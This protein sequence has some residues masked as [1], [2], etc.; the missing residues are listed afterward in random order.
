MRRRPALA[1]PAVALVA[2]LLAAS[3]AGCGLDVRAPDLFAV[4]R[5][6]QGKPLTMVVNFGG[7][8]SCEGGPARMLPDK[9]LLV[10][11]DLAAALGPD[12]QRNL[13]LPSPPGSVYRF[14]VRLQAGTILFPDTAAANRPALARLEQFVL[15]AQPSCGGGG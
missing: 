5:T 15:Q 14:K 4:T 11:R 8:V 2:A 6:G 10:A 12:A 3:L 13:D 9:L 7:S 1:S